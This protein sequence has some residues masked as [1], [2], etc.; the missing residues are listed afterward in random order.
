MEEK[1]Y[2]RTVINII[3]NTIYTF[4]SPAVAFLFLYFVL[5]LFKMDQKLVEI[6]SAALSILIFIWML[7]ILFVDDKVVIRVTDQGLFYKSGKKEDF[8]SF[9]D[10]EFGYKTVSSQGSTDTI[11]LYVTKGEQTLTLNCEPIGPRQFEEMFSTIKNNTMTD[12][13]TRLN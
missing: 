9:E 12:T 6:I 13:V 8:Y 1:I 5:G 3:K 2:K 7:K 11:N 10:Y 4:L